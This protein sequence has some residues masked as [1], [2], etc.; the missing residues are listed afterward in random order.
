MNEKNEKLKIVRLMNPS[1]C[2]ECRFATVAMVSMED[3]TE[4]KMMHCK[5]LDCDN[6]QIEETDQVPTQMYD[7]EQ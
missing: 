7:V 5:R 6:W 1:L 3:G 4:R 2:A